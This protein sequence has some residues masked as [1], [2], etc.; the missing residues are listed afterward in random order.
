MEV[1]T[2]AFPF[3]FGIDDR[4]FVALGQWLAD[5]QAAARGMFGAGFLVHAAEPAR[6]RIIE[7]M[8]AEDGVY[9]LD[10]T[11]GELELV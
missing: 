11:F 2:V 7:A 1:L 9:L 3:Q 5:A 8:P 6:A 10:E 4:V